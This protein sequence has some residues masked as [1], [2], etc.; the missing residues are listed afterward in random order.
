[1]KKLI[2]YIERNLVGIAIYTL[3]FGIAIIFL[4]SLKSPFN[5][6]SFNTNPELFGL[7]GNFI[8]G[9]VGTLFSLVAVLLLY[10]TLIAQQRS[11]TKQDEVISNQKLT[12]EIER[13]ETTFFNLLKT[14]QEIT[15]NIKS[16]FYS[17]NDNISTVTYTVQGREFFAYSRSELSK[18]W[19]TIEN[20]KYL[21][22]FDEDD[23]QYIQHEI[24]QLYDPSS[25]KFTSEIDANYE[26]QAIMNK[27]RL[28]LAIKQYRISNKYWEQ[29][30]KYDT[31]KKLEVIYGLFFQRYHYAIGH[32][33]RHLYHIINFVKQ[34]EKS[35]TE[36]NEMSKRYIDFIQAQMSSYEMML[37]FYN[38]ISFP[39]LLTLL[40]KYNFLE[41]LAIEDLIDE[42]HNCISGIKLKTRKK[43]LG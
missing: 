15:N 8:G 28:K 25:P 18:I 23:T 16:Y 5:D 19:K 12:S 34:F 43:L 27:E 40:I 3:V 10:K 39:R 20:D 32:Y 26:E 36:F 33:Y 35:R 31:Q 13:F 11:L 17:L 6:W 29:V 2:N 41:N 21:G 42:S 14:Q 37:L 7:Y 24:E 22:S 4:F 1:M 9:F 38:A 30:H